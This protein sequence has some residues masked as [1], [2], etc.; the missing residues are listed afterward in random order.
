MDAKGIREEKIKETKR[1]L[2]LDAAREVFA[3]KGYHDTRLEDI[4]VSAG[5]SKASLYNYYQDKEDLFFSLA[6]REYDNI[7][8]VL[9]DNISP[10]ATFSENL[11]RMLRTIFTVFG[12]HF[13]IILT[14]NHAQIVHLL[15]VDIHKHEN[16]LGAFRERM[17]RIQNIFEG[18]I[19]QAKEKGEVKS[20]QD[21][22][23]LA[24]FLGAQIRG[25]LFDWKIS[26]K[27]GNINDSVQQVV[28]FLK[29]GFNCK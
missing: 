11:E 7:I 6:T 13:A 28:E 8:D 23:V 9:K 16:L 20:T 3:E 26:G 29:N 27:M 21:E 2:I 4:A 19:K 1:G 10:E 25:V 17:F 14:I 5:F 15:H 22:A 12:K 24:R 18:A